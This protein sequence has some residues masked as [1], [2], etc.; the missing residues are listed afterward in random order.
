MGDSGSISLNTSSIVSCMRWSM[1]SILAG[2]WDDRV[3]RYM[4]I[5]ADLLSDSDWELM[6]FISVLTPS[7]NGWRTSLTVWSS[8]EGNGWY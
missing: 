3:G 8:T 5:S 7:K 1:L 2:S 4:T 6:S